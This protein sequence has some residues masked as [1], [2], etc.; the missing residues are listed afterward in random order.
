MIE[1]SKRTEMETIETFLGDVFNRSL[2]YDLNWIQEEIS[3]AEKSS[4][5]DRVKVA[6]NLSDLIGNRYSAY[7]NICARIGQVSN[8]WFGKDIFKQKCDIVQEEM[9]TRLL[10]SFE[11]Q[12]RTDD[13]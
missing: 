7:A 8:D 12:V 11:L 5:T 10:T 1:M 3:K 13:Y 9:R 4:G 6:E 2:E